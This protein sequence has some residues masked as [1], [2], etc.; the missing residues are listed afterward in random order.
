MKLEIAKIDQ[1]AFISFI[2]RLKLI[3]S[4]IYFKI[5]DNQVIST[6]YPSVADPLHRG[7][8]IFSAAEEYRCLLCLSSF[9]DDP[10]SADTGSL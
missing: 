3:D 5:K 7:L 10:N 8:T 1:H 2:N 6:V 9:R 4:F